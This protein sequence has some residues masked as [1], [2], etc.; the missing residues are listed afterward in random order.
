VVLH[1]FKREKKENC[2]QFLSGGGKGIVFEDAAR[3]GHL[4]GHSSQSLQLYVQVWTLFFLLLRLIF[5][6]ESNLIWVS[7]KMAAYFQV[8]IFLVLLIA[9]RIDT[10]KFCRNPYNV[11]GICNRSSCPLANSRYATIR[12]HEGT[13]SY[14]NVNFRSLVYGLSFLLKLC[15]WLGMQGCSICTWKLLRELICP[16]SC[17]KGLSCPEIM[18]RRLKSLISIWYWVSALIPKFLC[19]F[20]L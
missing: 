5:N 7:L 19:F 11:T 15:N 17:G 18:R 1:P 6:W 3:W 14:F 8:G 16:T 2:H 13:L 9:I 12:D 4:A 10:G 20:W